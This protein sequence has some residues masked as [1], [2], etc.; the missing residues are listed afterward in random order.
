MGVKVKLGCGEAVR[1]GVT[2]GRLLGEGVFTVL[3]VTCGVAVVITVGSEGEIS[4]LA[5]VQ[6]KSKET[7]MIAKSTRG[8]QRTSIKFAFTKYLIWGSMICGVYYN[9]ITQS[10]IILSY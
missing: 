7:K 10:R 3:W 1:E 5:V 4:W 9:H 6:L 2:D 8:T